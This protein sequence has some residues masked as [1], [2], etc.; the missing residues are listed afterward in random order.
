ME[1]LKGK[2]EAEA[3]LIYEKYL[4]ERLKKAGLR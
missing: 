3:F 4:G 2:P 1:I